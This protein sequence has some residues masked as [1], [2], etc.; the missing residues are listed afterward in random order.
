MTRAR[1]QPPH[2]AHRLA[3]ALPRLAE[4]G[5]ICVPIVAHGARVSLAAFRELGRE[6]Q[7]LV[8]V[9]AAKAL[10]VARLMR[11]LEPRVDDPWARALASRAEAESLLFLGRYEEALEAYRGT[12]RLYLAQ[13][14]ELESARVSVGE[15]PALM[16]LSRFREA[17]ALGRRAE[18]VLRRHGERSYLGRLYMNVGS[19]HF[20]MDRYR[21]ARAF[22]AKARRELNSIGGRD[23]TV[24]G[25]EMNEG[26]IATN[27]DEMRRAESLLTG[28]IAHARGMGWLA[29]AAQGEF[30]LATVYALGSRFQEALGALTRAGDVF[31]GVDESL[32]AIARQTRAEIYL[33]LNMTAEAVELSQNA[34]TYFQ[35][36][37]MGYDAALA[38]NLLGVAYLR[39]GRPQ[40]A[41]VE[42]LAAHR[43]F[44]REANAVRTAGLDMQLAR[45]D[46]AEGRWRRADARARAA[47]ESLRVR[48]LTRRSRRA[49]LLRAEIALRASRPGEARALLDGTRGAPD[50]VSRFERAFLLGRVLEAEAAPRRALTQYRKADA[51]AES[52]RISLAGEEHKI[53]LGRYRAEV[54]EHAVGLVLDTLP[55]RRGRRARAARAVDDAF[56][57]V[58]GAK[59]RALGDL[60]SGPGARNPRGGPRDLRLSAATNRLAWFT[61]KLEREEL[62]AAAHPERLATLRREIA[63]AEGMVTA[64]HRRGRELATVGAQGNAAARATPPSLSAV[65]VSLEEGDVL[66]EYFAVRGVVHALRVDRWRADLHQLPLRVVDAER[67]ATRL[68]FQMDTVRQCGEALRSHAALLR[69]SARAALADAYAACLAPL[70]PFPDAG[71]LIVVPHGPLHRLPFGALEDARGAPLWATVRVTGAPSAG[72]LVQLAARRASRRRETLVGGFADARAPHIREEVRAVARAR[73]RAGEAV[74]RRLSLT[75]VEFLARAPTSR[76]IHVAVHGRFRADNPLFSALRFADR[77]LSLYEI[78]DVPMDADLVALSGCETGV[79]RLSAG[80]ELLGLA[81]GFLANGARR[82][83]VSLWPVNDPA[84]AALAGGFH[85]NVADGAAPD[86]ALRRSALAVRDSW[87][88]PYYWA[89]VVLLGKL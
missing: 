20:H 7:R 51:L 36:T 68:S 80:D 66:V 88:H 67:L 86:E 16:Y 34:L 41:R 72:A 61:E 38:R 50:A 60:L 75:A 21:E 26:V 11:R 54:A 57:W 52:L 70:G 46:M 48:G 82:L 31:D 62:L 40:A 9:D 29:L 74:T 22:Y 65:Q 71:R 10:R 56:R 28:A 6:V 25:L 83:L 5:S 47:E 69:T 35:R 15:I 84:A 55:A 23:E 24:V 85:A 8:R 77:W 39:E 4:P 58:E 19:L 1:G 27:L 64:L 44:T 42:L 81:G 14:D 78:L 87:P 12:V 49:R 53:A 17:L 3:D 73:R 33:R 37:G 30:D 45:V 13:G 89:P 79:Q 76:V 43:F 63:Q 2:R 59:A 32:A 18:L